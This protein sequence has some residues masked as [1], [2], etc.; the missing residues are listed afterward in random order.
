MLDSIA[1]PTAPQ[2]MSKHSKG[3]LNSKTI[4]S[5]MGTGCG[6]VGRAVASNTRDPQ[7]K[8]SHLQNLYV[9]SSV[10]K[11]RKKRKRGRLWHLLETKWWRRRL[12]S[13]A[14]IWSRD[15][16]MTWRTFCKDIFRRYDIIKVSI[17]LIIRLTI[18]H[19]R[20]WS[21]FLSVCLSDRIWRNSIFKCLHNS[22]VW[23]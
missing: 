22:K 5:A 11:R 12:G 19:L 14:K 4:D 13:P 8:F 21:R 1:L 10:L 17:Y 16:R 18:F 2:R 6:A 7:F 9:L 23:V 15:E 3:F 20:D